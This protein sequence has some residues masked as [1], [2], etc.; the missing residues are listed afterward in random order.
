MKKNSIILFNDKADCCGCGACSFVCKASAISM[1]RD[2]SGFVYPEIN[3][4]LCIGCRACQKICAFNTPANPPEKRIVYGA[5]SKITD[6]KKSSSGGIFAAAATRFLEKGGIVVGAEMTFSDENAVPKLTC[7]SKSED[8]TG[9]TGSKYVQ[10]DID[11]SFFSEI[12]KHLKEGRRIL[13][14]GTPCQVDAVKKVFSRYKDQLFLI[15]IVCHGTPS[16]RFLND[17]LKYYS[18]INNIKIVDFIFRDKEK[19]GWDLSGSLTYTKNGEEKTRKITGNLSSYYRLFLDGITYRDSCYQCKY[20]SKNRCGDITIG[21][22]WGFQRE[23]PDIAIPDG[24]SCLIINTEKGKKWLEEY[25]NDFEL[26]QS[27]YEIAAG[28][29]SQLLKPV[30]YNNL[31]DRIF[32]A[33][34]RSGYEGVENVFSREYRIKLIKS[35][36]KNAVPSWVKAIIREIRKRK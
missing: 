32:S 20:A 8:L 25:S 13:F 31:R 5:V 30:K 11:Y 17:W 23:Y 3:S 7:I 26:H 21:D 36:L 27:A 6:I 2:I 4:D 19:Y 35:R 14:S 18:S 22:F 29:N 34:S 10:C 24:I 33:Y 16:S 9:L 12:E 15:D 1:K 28:N